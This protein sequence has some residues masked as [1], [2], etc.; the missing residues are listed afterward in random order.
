MTALSFISH[1]PPSLCTIPVPLLVLLFF[2][3]SSAH[4]FLLS[5]FKLSL[6]LTFLSHPSL[7]FSYLYTLVAPALP[8]SLLSPTTLPVFLAPYA[9]SHTCAFTHLTW[10]PS[11]LY[12]P[13]LSLILTF[14][15]LF[16]PNDSGF[17]FSFVPTFSL[18]S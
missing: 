13:H 8:F 7:S 2:F 4:P 3:H 18:A 16:F 10:T 1:S 14:P 9:C 11:L 15:Y 6:S 17:F 12:F 5:P